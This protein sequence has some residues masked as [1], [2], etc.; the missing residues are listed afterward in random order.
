MPK[1]VEAPINHE[2][3]RKCNI[4]RMRQ[5]EPGPEPA[6]VP[7]GNGVQELVRRVRQVQERV[8]RLDVSQ[9]SGQNFN[10]EFYVLTVFA[11]WNFKVT[12]IVKSC[13]LQLDFLACILHCVR[14]TDN[15][16]HVF[17]II[18]WDWSRF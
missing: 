17:M 8:L 15:N 3:N 12:Y 2:I 9:G 11:D 13:I 18:E 14:R 1:F 4:F 10:A 5:S 7:V 16:V 6:G